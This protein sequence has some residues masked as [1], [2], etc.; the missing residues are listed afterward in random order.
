[1]NNASTKLKNKKQHWLLIINYNKLKPYPS[2]FHGSNVRVNRIV[3]HP[4]YDLLQLLKF[5]VCFFTDIVPALIMSKHICT[6]GQIFEL[7]AVLD[8]LSTAA[9]QPDFACYLTHSRDK[10]RFICTFPGCIC[11]KVCV[12]SST[13]H[14]KLPLHIHQFVKSKS[15]QFDIPY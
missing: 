12:S 14:S 8:W 6:G 10:K 4:Q 3:S 13:S 15:C 9:R 7:S 1:M 11:A 5:I 2:T